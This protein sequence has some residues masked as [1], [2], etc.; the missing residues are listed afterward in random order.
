MLH[1]QR[2]HSYGSDLQHDD[3]AQRP[4]PNQQNKTTHDNDTTEFLQGRG[5]REDGAAGGAN[6]AAGVTA[7]DVARALRQE[8]RAAVPDSVKAELLAQIRAFMVKL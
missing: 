5:G 7:E 6:A 4:T 8:G 3:D 1:V 2:A